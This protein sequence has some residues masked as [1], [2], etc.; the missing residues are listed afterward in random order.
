M[1]VLLRVCFFEESLVALELVLEAIVGTYNG[2]PVADVGQSLVEAHSLSPHE[3]DE[4]ESG[5]LRELGGTLEM[6]AA[7]WTRTW[8]FCRDYSIKRKAS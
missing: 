4:D 6:P 5:G 1:R 8:P 3:I 2:P 7:Q